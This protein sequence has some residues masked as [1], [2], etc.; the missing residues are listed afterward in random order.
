MDGTLPFSEGKPGYSVSIS[1]VSKK[2]TPVLGVVYDPVKNNLYSA[3]R[4]L[5]ATKNGN[6]LLKSKVINSKF[7]L[8]TDRS[9]SASIDKKII[10]Q[11]FRDKHKEVV[12]KCLGGAVLNALWVIE[13]QPSCY[14]KSIK[15]EVGGGSIWDFS[16]TA[17]I[18]IES[19]CKVS[20]SRGNNLNL[21]SKDSAFMNQVGVS[22][23][24]LYY[25]CYVNYWI[26]IYFRALREIMIFWISEV[27][28]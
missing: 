7:S 20:D 6:K 21:N 26:V 4:G 8:V 12:L 1:L 5:G 28:S 18:A 13:N 14:F 27:P 10:I 9:F 16:A 22:F 23:T 2:G 19:G 25:R 15:K 17:C 24:W 11:Q 3:V